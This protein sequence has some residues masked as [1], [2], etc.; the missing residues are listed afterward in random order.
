MSRALTLAVTAQ[1]FV[2]QAISQMLDAIAANLL[3]LHQ[4]VQAPSPS[5]SPVRIVYCTGESCLNVNLDELYVKSLEATAL[6]GV[7]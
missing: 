1:P 5:K 4:S 6:S 2:L 7:P 3:C